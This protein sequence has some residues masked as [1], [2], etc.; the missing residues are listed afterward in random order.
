MDYRQWHVGMKV[1]CVDDGC[2]FLRDGSRTK[3]GLS[4][5]RIYTIEWIGT[6][7][8]RSYHGGNVER[9]VV[10]RLSGVRHPDTTCSSG[11]F[12][13]IRFRPVEPRTTN[14]SIFQAMLTPKRETERA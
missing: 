10:I 13:A 2:T 7:R 14:I 4:K 12:G 11:S 8:R 1:V 6:E 5:G 3:S 9:S